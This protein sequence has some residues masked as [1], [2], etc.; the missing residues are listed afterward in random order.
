MT[1]FIFPTEKEAPGKQLSLSREQK[2]ISLEEAAKH[3][4]IRKEYLIAL[5]KDQ[6]D[7]L[8]SGL[9]G[10]H[11]LKKYCRLLKL[12]YRKILAAS[13]L[14][15]NSNSVDPFSKKIPRAS[16]FFIF[17]KLI[18]NILFISLF[19]IFVIYFI[20]YF[21]QLSAPPKLIIKYP[22][23]NLV[24]S[25]NNL[26]I[27]GYSDPETEIIIN[28]SIVMSSQDG[29]F[30]KNIQLKSGLNTINISA[31]KKHGRAI[32]LQRQILVKDQY[33]E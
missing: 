28:G 20:F 27:Q 8:P 6:Y 5:E 1:E 32:N 10:K 9:Y 30:N 14:A 24:I 16:N 11:F 22:E 18:R 12:N 2:N 31:K 23:T 13:P 15:E 19:L 29:N 25:D 7:Q 21:K 3:L 17:P 4:H 33:D 26:T